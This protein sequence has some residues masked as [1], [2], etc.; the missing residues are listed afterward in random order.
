M[1]NLPKGNYKVIVTDKY[2]CTGDAT[3]LVEENSCCTIWVPNAFTPNADGNNDKFVSIAN[4]PIPKYEMSI[5]NRWGQRVFYTT[6]Y[7][8]GW[9]GTHNNDGT[10]L[11]LGNYYYRIK[12]TC[13]MGKKE[14]IFQGDVTLIR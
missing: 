9:D 4:R 10:P 6:K 14:M 3:A 13:E 11:D 2:G 8:E 12:Y 1:Q 7:A 5:F